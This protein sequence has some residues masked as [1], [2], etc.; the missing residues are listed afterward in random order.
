MNVEHV[1]PKIKEKTQKEILEEQYKQLKTTKGK[2]TTIA[3]V[4]E[5]LEKL[6]EVLGLTNG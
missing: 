5:R 4:V 1:T 6:E 3:S 2:P